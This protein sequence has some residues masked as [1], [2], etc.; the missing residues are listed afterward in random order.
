MF[1]DKEDLSFTILDVITLT[2]EKVRTVNMPRNYHALSYRFAANTVIET[3]NSTYNLYENSV[4]FVPAGLEYTRTCETDSL[5][6]V[7]FYLSNYFPTEINHFTAKNSEKMRSLFQELLDCW[8]KKDIGYKYTAVSIFSMILAECYKEN[9]KSEAE[10]SPIAASVKY[11]T[12]NF[13]DTT[14]TIKQIAEKSFISE[15]Y[16]RKLFKA[17]YKTSPAKYLVELRI[18]NSVKL[19][20]TGYYT[21]KEAAAL[22]GY[23]DYS[24]FSAEFKRLKGVSPSKYNY[25]FWTHG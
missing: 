14:I 21:L 19:M 9:Y 5:I 7:H 12:D 10:T 6:V 22:S 24:Y 25:T 15:V 11:M 2:Q 18:E 3:K 8:R 20:Q 17:I 23:C 16:F 1:F 4:C 13:A